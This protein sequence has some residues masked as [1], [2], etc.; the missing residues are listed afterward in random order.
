MDTDAR[1]GFDP[2]WAH[3]RKLLALTRDDNA[4]RIRRKVQEWFPNDDHGKRQLLA[5]EFVAGLTRPD[6][7]PSW[8]PDLSA[9]DLGDIVI[10]RGH[11]H[12]R[13]EERDGRD[14]CLCYLKGPGQA[15]GPPIVSVWVA[16]EPCVGST[17]RTMLSGHKH[18]AVIG[19][20]QEDDDGVT[21]DPIAID[22][23]VNGALHDAPYLESNAYQVWPK[24]SISS[25]RLTSA[26]TPRRRRATQLRTC[27]KPTSNRSLLRSWASLF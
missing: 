1:I 18:C 27:S 4:G 13:R 21:V 11:W 25:P 24:T 12:F 23:L 20:K 14:G 9:A 26:A 10:I 6:S 3:G 17:G 15:D 7:T 2:F 16:Y 22:Y 19:W 5:D 8:S